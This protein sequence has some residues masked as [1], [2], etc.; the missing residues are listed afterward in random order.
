MDPGHGTHYSF[1]IFRFAGISFCPGCGLGNAI[2]FLFHGDLHASLS[3]H[4]LGLF[5]LIVI[6]LR[7]IKL[8]SLHI[9]SNI[10]KYGHAI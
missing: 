9:F 6:L 1:C 5:A 2:S 4:P 8:S 10:K 3:A 7:I